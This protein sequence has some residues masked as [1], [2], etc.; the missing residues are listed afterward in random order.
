MMKK[1]FLTTLVFTA[2]LQAAA[3][4]ITIQPGLPAVG[5]IQKDQ[6]WNVL[7]VNGSSTNMK[8]RLDVMLRDRVTGNEC[9]S[10]SSSFFDLNSGA[11][12]L[13][14]GVLGPV[15]YNYF[16]TGFSNKLQG[17]LPA[18]SYTACYTLYINT[19]GKVEPQAEECVA[20]DTE[21]LS[22]PMLSFPADSSV[23]DA[24]P[25]Q[26][27]WMPPTPA[28][29]FERLRYEVLISE[30]KPGQQAAEALAENMPFYSEAFLYSNTLNHPA[31]SPAFEKEKWYAWQVVA[32]DDNNYA[33]KTEVWVFKVT[34]TAKKE[35]AAKTYVTL[36]NTQDEYGTYY[37][38]ENL[39]GIKYYSFEK[40]YKAGIRVLT[41]AGSLVQETEKEIAYGDNLFTIQLNGA[42]KKGVMY[43]LELVTASGSKKSFLFSITKAGK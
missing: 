40:N 11:R 7:V 9:M 22:P 29:M 32:K 2:L 31:A 27:T 4:Q 5:M 34:A 25:V 18:G 43:R 14:T 17:L 30:V 35:E 38:G 21:P 39:V 10:G 33:G 6:L 13:N 41:A 1:T 28:G 19:G 24:A 20:F 42:V 36:S 26:F 23:L 16:S 8:C 15:Q 3:A 37:L 12:Q